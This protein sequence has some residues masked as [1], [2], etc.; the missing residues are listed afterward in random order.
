[1][2]KRIGRSLNNYSKYKY[3]QTLLLRLLVLYASRIFSN[4][5]PVSPPVPPVLAGATAEGPV[6]NQGPAL[7]GWQ[8][9]A[10]DEK[11]DTAQGAVF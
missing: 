8:A 9:S 2:K 7:E 3:S 10:C 6:N 4:Q 5:D 11:I 1:M